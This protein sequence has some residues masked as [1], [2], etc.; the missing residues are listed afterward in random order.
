MVD[1]FILL[2]LIMQCPHQV[3]RF[4]YHKKQ[5]FQFNYSPK[6]NKFI[7]LVLGIDIFLLADI[8]VIQSNSGINASH[9]EIGFTWRF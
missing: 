5:I 6:A 2:C 7:R 1:K 4:F 9:S 8:G 3:N